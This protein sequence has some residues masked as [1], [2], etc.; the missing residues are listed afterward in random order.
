[1]L[2]ALSD[3]TTALIVAVAGLAGALLGGAASFAGTWWERRTERRH[4]HASDVRAAC[5]NVVESM[6]SLM[7][8][9]LSEEFDLVRRREA[10]LDVTGAISVLGLNVGLGK[11]LR[12][13]I[14]QLNFASDAL[15]EWRADEPGD[16]QNVPAGAAIALATFSVAAGTYIESLR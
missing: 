1:M 8:A 5:V 9:C 15:T 7:Q 10:H 12:N 16:D 11:A 3:A 14:L 2:L 4:A 6:T 13:E